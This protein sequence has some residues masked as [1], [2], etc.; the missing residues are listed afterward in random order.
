MDRFHSPSAFFF[1][2]LFAFLIL[3]SL[4]ARMLIRSGRVAGPTAQNLA[5]R[6]R[7]WW[8]MIGVLALIFTL[9]AG[10]ITLFFALCSMAALREF[11]TITHTRRDDHDG[12]AI[13]FYLIL[14]LQYL[15]VYF[16]VPVF[17]ALLIPVYSFLLLPVVTVFKG[18][19]Q[20]FLTRVSETQWGL[21]VCVYCVSHIPAILTLDIPDYR[22]SAFTLVAWLILVVQASDV[23]QYV[24][25]KS[26]GRHLLAP[27]VSPSKTVE[28]L[29]GGV[30]SASALGVALTPFTPF[31][32]WEAGLI[33]LTVTTFGFFGGLIMSAIKRDRGVK[34]WGTLVQGHG[35]ILD[36]LDSLVFSAPIFLHILAW[37]WM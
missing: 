19:V 30:L 27:R 3:A 29:V 8:V 9:G 10:A 4:V 32:W 23:L 20:G 7:A 12:L 5:D 33:A 34:D 13:A 36:R 35:G 11:A 24:W 26:I 16:H 31:R 22:Y 25:G 6:I 18:E 14:P 15:L 21:M 1:Y 17:A 2:G 37:G 28:G